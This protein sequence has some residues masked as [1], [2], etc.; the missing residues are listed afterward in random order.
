MKHWI[1][2]CL[3]GLEIKNVEIKQICLIEFRNI[4]LNNNK[5]ISYNDQDEK[6]FNQV[7]ADISEWRQ[8]MSSGFKQTDKNVIYSFIDA[9]T[10]FEARI[11]EKELSTTYDQNSLINKFCCS[12]NS[13]IHG[14]HKMRLIKEYVKPTH[15]HIYI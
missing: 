11:L 4:I 2:F 10:A 3:F 13:N 1:K 12:D 7:N 15:I 6:S 9:I 14:G 5:W 8:N